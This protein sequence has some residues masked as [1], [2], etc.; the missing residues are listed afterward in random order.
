[1]KNY[2]IQI[3][4]PV[5]NSV[6]TLERCLNSL[7]NQTYQN[8]QA[9][10]IDDAST[11]NSVE[12]IERYISE[13]ERFVLLKQEKNMGV[14]HSRNEGLKHLD[15][16]YVA[17]LDSDDF[18]EENMLEIMYGN[19]EKYKCDVVQ[20]RYVYDFK[21]GKQILP[22][23]AFKKET[24]L[25]G[26][27]LKRVYRKMMTGI[28]MN[29]VCMKLIKTELVSGLEFN[30]HMR[31]AEDLVFCI[32]LFKRVKS[33][34]FLPV[35]LYH[36]CRNNSSLTG[37]TLT[38]KQKLTANNMAAD[39]LLKALPAWNIDRFEYRILTKFRAYIII[40]SKIFRTMREKIILLGGDT[41]DR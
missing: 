9:I 11:D 27:N 26:S 39:A 34:L 18:W 36:Y 1:M 32:D 19:A 38:A 2:E 41:N 23:G 8:W 13:D 5:Y 37:N 25:T 12:I 22:A 21:N 29:H 28:N 20:C 33:Y 4:V 35:S 3:I 15:S 31:T 7:K 14:S 30:V 24:Y 17:F 6:N 16:K 40:V 10:L